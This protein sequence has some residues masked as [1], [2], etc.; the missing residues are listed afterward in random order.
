LRPSERLPRRQACRCLTE[1]GNWLCQ[2]W[3]KHIPNLDKSLLGLPWYRNEVGDRL[4]D[5]IENE[6]AVRK[7]R[8]DALAMLSLPGR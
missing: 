2:G 8:K 1:W 6:R 3:S 5:K 7:G 4:I